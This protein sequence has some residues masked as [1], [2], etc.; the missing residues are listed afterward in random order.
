[1]FASP[2]ILLNKGNQRLFMKIV[3]SLRTRS[4]RK[5]T[6]INL[7]RTRCCLADEFNF[8]PSNDAIWKF[9]LSTDI[10]RLTRNFLWKAM[11]KTYR[12]GAFRQHIPHLEHL[13]LCGICKVPESM[14]HIML[15]C[16]S[17][18]QELIWNL[19]ERLWRLRHSDWP[20]LNW[21]LLL[22]SGL[23]R[24]R[25]NQ[26]KLMR[27]K[28]RLFKILVY[29][30]MKLIWKLRN[31]RDEV[32]NRWLALINNALKRDQLLTNRYRFGN[33]ARNSDTVL[34]TWSGTLKDED[35]LPDDWTQVTPDC[36][37]E[38]KRGRK[39]RDG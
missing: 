15:E 5:S 31:E 36:Q 26:G 4:E 33:L 27:G 9:L 10:P 6:F 30:S 38:R 14:E 16:T 2:G 37:K 23:A 11:H 35:A 20:R 13:E 34:Q 7:E 1:M 25:S 17:P 39:R 32:H 18:A 22:G 24:F 21:G 19:A 12:L 29:T 28:N 8:S 3:M